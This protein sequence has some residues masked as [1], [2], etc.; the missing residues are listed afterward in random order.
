[1]H[2]RRRASAIQHYRK[3]KIARDQLRHSGN[4]FDNN[5]FD[6]LQPP[7]ESADTKTDIWYIY[8]DHK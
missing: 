7:R 5:L 6:E 2:Y 3:T 8:D 1:M 4:M